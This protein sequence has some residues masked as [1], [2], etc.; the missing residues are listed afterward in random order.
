[1]IGGGNHGGDAIDFADDTRRYFLREGANLLENGID[2]PGLPPNSSAIVELPIDDAG[3]T[4]QVQ[5]RIMGRRGAPTTA[6]STHRI[7][8][9]PDGGRILV[10]WDAPSQLRYVEWRD[11]AWTAPLAV[12][13]GAL[14]LDA[15]ESALARR[16]R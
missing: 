6:E 12:R 7:Y 4:H 13:L 3:A 14:S 1:I 15:A 9:S 11:T 5:L 10:A 16:V 8:T 2:N